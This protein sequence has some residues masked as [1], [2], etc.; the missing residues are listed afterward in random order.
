MREELSCN[1]SLATDWTSCSVSGCC[2]DAIHITFVVGVFNIQSIHL[3][4]VNM[5]MH[6]LNIRLH[7][8][9]NIQSIHLSL[10][11]MQMHP[12]NNRLHEVE[13]YMIE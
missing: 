10:V 3:S 8:V 13:I 2:S 9:F 12:L 6:P 4:L 5:Q 1:C 11:N 7:E